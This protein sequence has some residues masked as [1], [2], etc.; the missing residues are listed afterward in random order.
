MSY[1]I[2]NAKWANFQ[3]YYDEN[4]HFDDWDDSNSDPLFLILS[5]PVY[6]LTP[7]HCILTYEAA[8]R[9]FIV[10]LEPVIYHSQAQ[11]FN[12]YITIVVKR[13]V[14]YNLQSY[15]SWQWS[16]KVSIILQYFISFGHI[17]TFSLRLY[18]L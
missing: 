1:C 10:W 16:M 13:E 17:S 8:N 15:K 12:K 3:L 14:L 2:C 5:R 4:L 18:I 7:K 6:A 11:Q 9:N